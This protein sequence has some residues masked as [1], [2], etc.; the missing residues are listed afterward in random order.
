MNRV[1]KSS[2]SQGIHLIIKE[3]LLLRFGDK[4]D[5]HQSRS[6]SLVDEKSA[7]LNTLYIWNNVFS[8]GEKLSFKKL[9]SEQ[10]LLQLPEGMLLKEVIRVDQ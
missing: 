5:S 7:E 8:R 2:K 6:Y 10:W 4:K 3:K 9:D 1:N